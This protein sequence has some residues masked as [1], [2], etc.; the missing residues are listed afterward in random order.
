MKKFRFEIDTGFVSCTHEVE[1][2]FED[3]VTEEE[4]NDYADALVHE[5]INVAYYEV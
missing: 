3:D 2:E 1:E 5:F 4:L